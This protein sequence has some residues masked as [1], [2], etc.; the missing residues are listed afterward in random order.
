MTISNNVA[1]LQANQ[2][3]LN[4]TANNIANVNTNRFVPSDTRITNNSTNTPK[5]NTRL[6]DDNGSQ[7][8]QTDLA[9][10]IPD[11]VVQSGVV[12]VNVAAIKTQ[13]E[14]FGTLLDIK[15]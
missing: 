1:S 3:F 15:V 5:A 11:Q 2:T 8:S 7:K 12:E 13:D 14:M 4:T 10:E 9:K 6:T